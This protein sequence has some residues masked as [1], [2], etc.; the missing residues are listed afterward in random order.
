MKALLPFF[1]LVVACGSLSAT[2][3][4]PEQMVYERESFG[5][6]SAPLDA[7]LGDPS[8]L[9]RHLRDKPSPTDCHRGYIASWKIDSGRLYLLSIVLGYERDKEI[10]L[11]EIRTNW[12]SP[13][14]AEWFSGHIRLGR[15]DLV[16]GG[17]GFS[18]IRSEEIL[19]E[20]K[21]E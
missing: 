20:I 5:M 1:C 17:M 11:S 16:M 18:E 6:Y 15:G 12:V 2:S 3:Q 8:T 9:P 7:Y 19:L 21:R 4:I 14:F 10:P 13:V